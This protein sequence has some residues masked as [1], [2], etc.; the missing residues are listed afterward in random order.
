MLSSWHGHDCCLWKGISCDNV[1]D[2]VVML[3]L[4]T[5]YEKCR[6]SLSKI[7]GLLSFMRVSLM[8]YEDE[9]DHLYNQYLEA[10]NVDSSLLQLKYLTHLDL[11]GN[12]F[13]SSPI[14]KFIGSMQHLRYL[15]LSNAGFGWTIPNNLGNL[16]NLHFLDLSHNVFSPDS[17]INW[18]SQLRL[19]EHLDM[20]FAALDSLQVN[21]N[22]TINA[23]KL[24]FLSLV[25]NG[26][27]VSILDALQNMTSLVHLNLGMWHLN[28][29]HNQIGG[30]LPENIGYIMPNL[31]NLLLGNNFINGSIPKSLCQVDQ[32]SI[33]DLSKNRLSGK[34]PDCWKDNKAWEEI[35]LSS[36]KLSGAFPNSFG[37]LSSL[38]WLHLNNNSLHGD[39]LAS[40]RNLTQLLIMDLGENQLSGTIPSWSAATFS[41]LQI[42][43]LRHNIL[44]GSIPSQ[45]CELSSLR[46][47][48]LSRNN[49][50]GSIPWCISNLRGMT[51]GAPNL[52]FTSLVDIESPTSSPASSPISFAS[53]PTS[54]TGNFSAPPP[55]DWQTED[56]IEV[57]KGREL[58]YIRIL[59]LVVIMDLSENNL[60]GS[61]P[62][63]I[64][65]L[66]GLHSLNLSHNHLIGEIP[67]M[68]GDMKSL[69][70]FDVSSN[71]LSGTIPSSMS[72]LTSLSQLNLSHNNFS[73]PI[74]TDNQFLTYDPSSYA[75]NPYLCGSPLP[76]KCGHSN[77][78][79][80]SSESEDED[81]KK[82]KLEKWLFYFVI[83]AGFATGFWGVI[84]TLWF[85]KTWRHA[86]FRRAEDLADMI[87]VTTAIRMAKLKKWMMMMRS[88]VNV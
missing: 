46:I 33:L 69:E 74:P 32:L 85:K 15:S 77:Q 62:K 22:L 43:R 59:K 75:D 37:N 79:H 68:I 28:L 82:D 63:G 66:N 64:T 42:L 4:T 48:D 17:N 38:A 8:S 83:A 26:L 11:S 53:S 13:Q 39:F 67:S 18:I 57:V 25:D 31:G 12:Y 56:V 30:S 2:H 24:Q 65:L 7:G 3:D 58:D 5:P 81:S 51:L 16:T 72:A 76:N 88:R 1:T 45:I 27:T 54:V 41:S 55:K 34:I 29:S 23:P 10:V 52:S 36:N 70:S 14:P 40:I 49:L 86:Y 80:G 47:L 84:G 21:I 44:S 19:L 35:N 50:N 61:I 60:V 20:S 78:V 9:C 6:R 73:G 87:Y 71:Q